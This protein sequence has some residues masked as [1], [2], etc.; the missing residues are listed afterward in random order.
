MIDRE[1]LHVGVRIALVVAVHGGGVVARPDA[2]ARHFQAQLGGIV[3]LAQELLARRGIELVDHVRG[4]VRERAAEAQHVLVRPG[5]VE[6]DG[7]VRRSFSRLPFQGRLLRKPL[8]IRR[9]PDGY[10]ACRL[11]PSRRYPG[12]RRYSACHQAGKLPAIDSLRHKSTSLC[13]L[14]RVSTASN[15]NSN[16]SDVARMR[17]GRVAFGIPM[18]VLTILVGSPLALKLGLV[19]H[20]LNSTWL[21]TLYA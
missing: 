18:S 12:Q 17:A 7:L 16:R 13:M 14:Y 1:A 4:S 8:R 19:C 21:K 9:L 3:Q 10:G 2:N 5:G 20:P 6:H 11:R 15:Q